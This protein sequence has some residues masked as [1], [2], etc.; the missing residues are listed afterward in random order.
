MLE[1]L[2]EWLIMFF[3]LSNALSTFMTV[4][5]EKLRLFIRIFIIVYFDDILVFS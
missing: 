5:N 1:F 2:F 4:M 3:G